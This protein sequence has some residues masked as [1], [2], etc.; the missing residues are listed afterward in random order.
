[1]QWC[2]TIFILTIIGAVVPCT[3]LVLV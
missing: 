2:V 3:S 1:V